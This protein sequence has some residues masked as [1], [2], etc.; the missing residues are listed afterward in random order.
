[1]SRPKFP[2]VP[3]GPDWIRRISSSWFQ[4]LRTFCEWAADHPRGD[5]QTILNTGGGILRANI[6]SAGGGE[7]GVTFPCFQVSADDAGRLKV[8]GG[9]LNRNGE[10]LL[11]KS[12]EGIDPQTGYLCLCTEPDSRGQW[13]E[14]EFKITEPAPA[15]YPVAEIKVEN[16][17]VSIV[18][19]PV[20][21]AMILLVKQCPIAEF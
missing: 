7:G 3:T 10:M 4:D 5:G 19:Y 21:V 16:G 18:Q 17:S 6:R 9:W 1:M 14:P 15:A 13:S 2:T 8:T 20:A 11:V 12:A